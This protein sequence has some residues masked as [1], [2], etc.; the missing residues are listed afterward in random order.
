MSGFRLRFNE[1]R[2]IT[3]GSSLQETLPF[4]EAF[5]MEYRYHG[6]S[7]LVMVKPIVVHSV[8]IFLVQ[9][10]D[11][12]ADS[13]ALVYNSKDE[14]SDIEKESTGVTDAI[15]MAIEKY[16]SKGYLLTTPSH[17]LN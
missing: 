5:E 14:W 7:N 11:E 1:L 12:E 15:G 3:Y 6:E 4:V 9:F 10:P 16:Y 8:V 17:L 2:N 13:M